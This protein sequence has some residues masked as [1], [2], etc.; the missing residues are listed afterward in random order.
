[1]E[2]WPPR[3]CGTIAPHALGRR[4]Y[5]I[6]WLVRTSSTAHRTSWTSMVTAC[7]VWY[8]VLTSGPPFVIRSSDRMTLVGSVASPIT[9]LPCTPV[10]TSCWLRAGL[11]VLL[12][13][14][15]TH[16]IELIS[17][18]S[19]HSYYSTSPSAGGATH[20]PPLGLLPGE[21]I[22]GPAAGGRWRLRRVFS[23]C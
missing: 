13:V 22:L 19:S 5:S 23:P 7:Y 4:L 8:K 3:L 14:R 10:R 21:S 16:S 17:V 1:M 9:S 12:A 20:A 2:I 18:S 6:N 15:S 11:A